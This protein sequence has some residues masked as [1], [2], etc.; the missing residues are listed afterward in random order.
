MVRDIDSHAQ[1]QHV[2]N[3]GPKLHIE[4]E[5]RR[6]EIIAHEHIFLSYKRESELEMVCIIIMVMFLC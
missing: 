6:E 5:V 4:M 1:V 2:P 3:I